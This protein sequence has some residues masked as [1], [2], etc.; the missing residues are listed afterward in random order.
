MPPHGRFR[1]AQN[2]EDR[3]VQRPPQPLDSGEP[4]HG[5]ERRDD[6]K[7]RLVVAF[8]GIGPGYTGYTVKKVNRMA[9]PQ[10]EISAAIFL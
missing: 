9:V 1:R 5:I 2:V 4:D 8:N 6:A 7:Q 3:A 10:F